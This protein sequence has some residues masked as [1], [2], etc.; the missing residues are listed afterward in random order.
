[1]EG[2][3]LIDRGTLS[4]ISRIKGI[5]NQDFASKDYFQEIMLLAISREF[6]Q[7]LFK[8]GTCLYKF[9]GLDRF[10]EDLD[11]VGQMKVEDLEIVNGYLND[12]GFKSTLETYTMRSGSLS[13]FKVRGFLYNGDDISLTRIRMDVTEKDPAILPPVMMKLHSLYPDIPAFFQST[14][15]PLEI[16]AEKFRSLFQRTKPRDLYDLCFLLDKGVKA[17]KDLIEKKMKAYSL[18]MDRDIF[19]RSLTTIKA[20]WGIE[21]KPVLGRIPNHEEHRRIAS[22][23]FTKLE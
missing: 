11:L 4:R 14:M 13:T 7:L 22:A 18:E 8:G 19:Q 6:P 1:L 16:L 15:D 10:S 2:E 23:L 20:N 12:F 5:S 9:H 17:D 21:M 3:A